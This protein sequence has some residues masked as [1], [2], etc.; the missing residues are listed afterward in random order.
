M[1]RA[2]LAAA[3]L[4]TSAI[5]TSDARA[6]AVFAF[7]DGAR[8][9][10]ALERVAI[11]YDESRSLEHFVREVRFDGADRAFAFVVP[12]PA[13]PDVEAVKSP[14]FVALERELPLEPPPEPYAHGIVGGAKS[15][16]PAPVEL[17]ET[18]R[19]GRFTAFVLA[20]SDGA[21]LAKWLADNRVALP[22]S[23]KSW[24]DHYVAL[25]FYFTAFRYDDAPPPVKDAPIVLGE[26]PAMTSE[27]VRLSFKTEL[28]FFPYLEPAHEDASSPPHEMH[29]WLVSRHE[30][31]ARLRRF[32]PDSARWGV[33]WEARRAYD[34]P[35]ADVVRPL[36]ELGALLPSSG[37]YHV[38]TFKDVRASRDGMGDVL[39]PLVDDALDD[40]ALAPK[41]ASLLGSLEQGLTTRAAEPGEL[42]QEARFRVAPSARGCACDV[43]ASDRGFAGGLAALAGL[44]LLVARRRR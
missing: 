35:A 25:S 3:A 26:K 22:P 23:G 17:L 12:T 20:A 13:R 9:G 43:G 7:G 5:A 2:L 1:K 31:A 29:V 30:R 10:V 14:P 36:G 44:A 24:L 4:T 39:F 28:P 18:R 8:P 21:A 33:A 41:L 32:L 37:D 6:C 16:A 42:E 27:T 11:L 19:V 40:P 15:A 34:K 38:Q